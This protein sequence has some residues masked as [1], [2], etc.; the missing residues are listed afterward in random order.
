MLCNLLS[1]SRMIAHSGYSFIFT[2]EAVY[3]VKLKKEN[4]KDAYRFGTKHKRLYKLLPRSTSNAPCGWKIDIGPN[5]SFLNNKS[6]MYAMHQS[7]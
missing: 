1:I 6:N 7:N 2:E 5:Y 3:A 4:L